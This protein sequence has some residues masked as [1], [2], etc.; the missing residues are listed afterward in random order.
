[1]APRRVHRRA[2]FSRDR[3]PLF[4]RRRP[5][6][7]IGA[8]NDVPLMVG[9]AASDVVRILL[10]AVDELVVGPAIDLHADRA[11]AWGVGIELDGAHHAAFPSI[12]SSIALR[13]RPSSLAS[14]SRISGSGRAPRIQSDTIS[15][16][17]PCLPANSLRV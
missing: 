13:E 1:M 4:H 14:L 8:A 17:S 6:E 15:G 3:S 5:A 9:V 12:S 16:H 11:A 2:C 7:P 10:A